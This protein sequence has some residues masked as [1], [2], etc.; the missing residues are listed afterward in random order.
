MGEPY[1]HPTITSSRPLPAPAIVAGIGGLVALVGV[2]LNWA[3]WTSSLEGGQFQGQQF[4][5]I[6]RSEGA[7]GIEHW[8]GILALAAALVAIAAAVGLVLLQDPGTRRMAAMA[9]TA[10]GALALL[11]AIL[12]ILMS[13]TL[14]VADLPG[15][16]Q[17]LD[18]ARQF[19]EQLGVEGF[20]IDTG[21]SIGV[22]VTA[23]G[24]A[25]AAVGG[26]MAFRQT[27]REPTTLDHQPPSAGMGFE[28][29]AEGPS[30][31]PPP[32][33]LGRPEDSTA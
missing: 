24:G 23:L 17:A 16:K 15:G 9:A 18:F 3:S 22:F 2:F 14:A 12:G 27:G 29:P 33:E 31:A 7:A 11:M 10:G 25:A 21:P 19:A 20:G 28:S 30:P 26:F 32:E 13:E 5:Q 1:T 8:T 4:G 6:S